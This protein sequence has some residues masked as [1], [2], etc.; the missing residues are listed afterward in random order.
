[1]EVGG[2]AEDIA[3]RETLKQQY[4][5]NVGL[6]TKLALRIL[7]NRDAA[8]DAVH[9]VF[10]AAIENRGSFEGVTNLKSFLA[11]TVQ[12]QALQVYRRRGIE[13]RSLRTR[14]EHDRARRSDR[15]PGQAMENSDAVRF[16][17]AELD[18]LR[19]LIVSLREI[20]G[21]TGKDV[22]KFVGLGESA[23]SRMLHDSFGRMRSSLKMDDAPPA[24]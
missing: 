11:M 14:E 13:R 17:L 4:V 18:D 15:P 19:R 3:W 16:A 5:R 6:Y 9:D 24:P 8:D 2:S 21:W 7:Q 20:E 12:R 23:I 1:M 22:A 10:R